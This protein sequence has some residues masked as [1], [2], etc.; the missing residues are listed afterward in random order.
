MKNPSMKI[1]EE[2]KTSSMGL[3]SE[4]AK[5]RLELYGPNVIVE[6]R[7]RK[8]LQKFIS[9]FLDP[10]A[11]LLFA[12]ASLCVM[13]DMILMGIVIF[14]ITI[15]NV[16]LSVFQEW[17]AEK[18]VEKLRAWMPEYA[19]VIRDGRV[20]KI[21]LK[22]I[23]P[24]D[25][26][27]LDEGSKVPADAV[28]VEAY[29]LWTSNVPL[30][31]ES[32]PQ[33]KSVDTDGNE[34]NFSIDA[35]N[36]VFMGTSVVKGSGKAVVVSTGMKTRFGGI[37]ELTEEIEEEESPFQKEI[38][39]M[40][41]YDLGIAVLVGFTFFAIGLLILKLDLMND[42]LFMIGTMIAL[43]PEGL[44]I[45]VSTALAMSILDM[46]KCNV[47]VKRLSS[48]QTLGSV[49]FVCMDKTGTITTGQMTVSKIWVYDK[50]IEVTGVGYSPLGDFL[51]DG[52]KLE[53]D[54]PALDMLM[55]ACTLCNNS[56]LEPPSDTKR[57]WE[58]IGDPTDGA[59]LVAA[60]KYGMDRQSLAI[61]K[62]LVKKIPFDPSKRRMTVV[63][64]SGAK[65]IAYT[66][67]SPRSVLSACSCIFVNG[68]RENMDTSRR[69]RI[70]EM[71]KNFGG[72]GLREI[73]V[74]FKEISSEEFNL[75]EG[76]I[77][78]GL[79]GLIDPPRPEIRDFVEKA[80][81]A[82]IKILIITG[83]YGPTAKA[84]AK[85]AGIVSDDAK[86]IRGV[87]MEAMSDHEILS[88]LRR[89]DV[90]LARVSPEQKLRIARILKKG[91]EVVAMVGDGVNDA[92]SLKEADIGIAMGLSG[93]DVAREVADMILLDDSFTSI[94]KAIEAGRAIY[95]NIKKFV[96]YVFTHNWAEL[97][98]YL[99]YVIMG[100]P[101][102][103]TVAQI[104]AI[105]LGIDVLPS[106]AL[107][108]E[109]PEEAIMEGGPR[110]RK[111]RL[112]DRS[113]ALKSL[114]IGIV[115]ATGAM[116]GCLM[117]WLK[118]GWRWGTPLDSRSHVYIK[119]VTMTFAGI[120]VGQ[121]GNLLTCRS[122][123]AS[124]LK[125]KFAN[126]KWLFFAIAIQL[127]I[128][129]LIIYIAPLQVVFTTT[130]LELQDW[131]YLAMIGISVIVIDELRKAVS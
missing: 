44:Q 77:F 17:R 74:A 13:S 26:I 125:M 73:A 41:K 2:L 100:I 129:F 20:M 60:L 54:L 31:G 122:R 64:R 34:Y 109:P 95:E 32:I 14:A 63:Y 18:A 114:F 11:L 79:V 55:E 5:K 81:R 108:R 84:I 40:A 46:V 61:D 85:M 37:V 4:E 98:P 3:N 83:D 92:P 42:I 62:E 35:P 82:G 113:V 131:A 93:T 59:L 58:I 96:A 110:D 102:P 103:L 111:E 87:D 21:P 118:G 115:I 8:L 9:N 22:E 89:G 99:L 116:I 124:I 1:F 43:V 121:I 48:T 53:E 78:L 27:L 91:G 28:L 38:A 51:Y 25:V 76:F 52:K 50:I 19:K 101:L 33:P 57:T 106:L 90:I 65:T 112:F 23:V 130:A 71:I 67:G 66:K 104:L 30:T 12:A 86:I 47:L 16:I 105:D 128:L 68:R 80:K 88:E 120:V 97:I 75:D 119:G 49:T 56:A 29:D 127:F 107:S 10:F 15:I 72:E 123:R 39:R 117:T 126:S 7:K 69:M 24:G 45:T 6:K 94:V 70:E 36:V